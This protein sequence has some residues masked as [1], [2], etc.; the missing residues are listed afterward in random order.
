MFTTSLLASGDEAPTAMSNSLRATAASAVALFA[1][2]GTV[3]PAT[4]QGTD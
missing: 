4:A 1:V 3:R 2:A